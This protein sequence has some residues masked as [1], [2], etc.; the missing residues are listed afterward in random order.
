M[1]SLTAADRDLLITLRDRLPG[2]ID[3]ILEVTPG[4][5][6]LVTDQPGP[7]RPIAWGSKVSQ[8]F[9]DRVW[10]IADTLAFD[11]DD[12]MT[13]MAWESGRSF[14][15]DI[16]NMAGSGATGLIQFMPKTAVSLGTTT[17]KLAQMTPEDQLSFVYKYLRPW[18]GKVKNLGDLYMT[19]LW[20]KAVGKPDDYALFTAGIAYRQNAGLDKNKDHRVT[21]AECAGKLYALKAE[22]LRVAA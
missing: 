5:V 10:W 2:M 4:P 13:C 7:R 21:K 22:G 9:R 14:R 1:A 3:R 16:R 17:T 6:P 11:P 12:L 19:I 18:G 15:A 20:P 8:T